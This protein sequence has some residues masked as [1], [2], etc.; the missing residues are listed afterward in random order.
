MIAAT[1]RIMALG[2]ALVAATLPALAQPANPIVREGVTEKISEHVHVIP[3]A[4]VSLVPNV[5]IIVGTRGAFVVDT[6][7]GKR[8][9]EAVVREVGKVSKGPEL[10]LA[11]THFH[12][13]HDLGAMAFPAHTKLLRST[14][15]Q[16][17]IEEFGLQLARTFAQRGPAVADLLKDAEFRKADTIF[18]REQVIDLGGVKVRVMAMG[19]NH[20]RGDTAFLVEPDGILFSGDVVMKPLPSFASPYSTIAHWR[21]SLDALEQLA[22]KKIVPSHGPIGEGTVL[23]AG[24]RDY[25]TTVQARVVALKKAGKSLE[26]TTTTLAAELAARYPDRQRLGGAIRAAYNEAK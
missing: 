1:P 5:G 7:L 6:G 17:D 25:F 11:T 23:I 9:G 21:T 19:A 13:E 15:Q 16:K 2:A 20:T 4:S 12:P 8:N 26:E 18:E 3:D 22:P 10:Y 24:Y 14:D